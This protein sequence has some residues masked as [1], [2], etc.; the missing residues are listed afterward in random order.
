MKIL[1][2]V[3]YL[4]ALHN[5]KSILLWSVVIVTP[6]TKT[7]E[8]ITTSCDVQVVPR[9]DPF[10]VLERLL[11][12]L[13]AFLV[14]GQVLAFIRLRKIQFIQYHLLYYY[15]HKQPHQSPFYSNAV[16]LNVPGPSYN[17]RASIYISSKQEPH[18]TL[19]DSDSLSIFI[20]KIASFCKPSVSTVSI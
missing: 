11:C 18:S 7:W 4:H 10:S 3:C 13:N 8:N 1:Q 5:N 6:F 17:F 2:A 20:S 12:V 9:W 19:V 14:Q 16:S 15:L